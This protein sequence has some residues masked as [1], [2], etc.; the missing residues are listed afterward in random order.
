MVIVVTLLALILIVIV[1]GAYDR[2]PFYR[3]ESINHIAHSLR[4]VLLAKKEE[5]ISED[6]F[7]REQTR[8]HSLLLEDSSV[9][10]RSHLFWILPAVIVLAIGSALSFR[11]NPKE[12]MQ[13][14]DLVASAPKINM[15]LI[16]AKNQ[17]QANQSNPPMTAQPNSGGDLNTMVKRLASKM[18]KDPNNGEG[19]LLLARTYNELRQPKEAANA[20][21]K[22]AALLPPDATM[23]ADWIDA[24]VVSND[25][26]WD[27][28]SK[29]IISRGLKL[30]PKHLKLL[31]LAGS[32][33]FERADYK[34]AISYWKQI[35]TVAP[36]GSK[37][38]NLAE[39]NIKEALALDQKK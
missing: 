13:S 10:R 5:R 9:A 30:D 3:R 1:L 7:I 33:A 4:E 29:E 28:E 26:K 27:A 35:Q 39:M 15:P 38:A 32:E 25:R 14:P 16:S 34:A 18:E 21:S 17:T 23:M 8:L 37:D 20:F 12:A 2:L 11:D 19:W 24:R 36:A 31:A 22:A 6:E